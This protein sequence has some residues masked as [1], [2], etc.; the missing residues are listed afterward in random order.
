VNNALI[1]IYLP[2]GLDTST[3]PASLNEDF[4]DSVE[5]AVEAAWMFYLMLKD[6]EWDVRICNEYPEKG[7]FLIHKAT[8]RKFVW[9]PRLFVV[10]MQWDYRRDDRGQVHLV[11]NE[12][13]TRRSSLGWLDRLS[14]AGLQYFIQPPMHAEIIRRNP[15]RGS[16]FENIAFIG[17][18]KNLAAE[19]RTQEFK[20]Q[21]AELGLRLLM[22]DDPKKM[23]DYAQIDAVI[24]VRKL[25]RLVVHKP[26]QKLVNA[27]RAGVP[28]IVGREIGYQELKK[29]DLDF[30]EIDSVDGMLAALKRLKS[31]TALRSEMMENG[32]RRAES[33]TPQALQARWINLFR[34]SIVPAYHDWESAGALR[35]YMFL[36]VRRVRHAVRRSASFI[37][38]TLLGI[39]ARI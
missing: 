30:L 23:S 9:H 5:Y 33:Y 29:S 20:E 39:K 35:R 21:M 25:G 19:F 37:V 14:F 24:A 31:D 13:K 28:C 36:F 10:S 12:F 18:E 1:N 26:P 22:V 16:R 6:H 11:A 7:I 15:E 34:D 2:K 8:V 4:K 3:F 38:H 27:W 32:L 17:E